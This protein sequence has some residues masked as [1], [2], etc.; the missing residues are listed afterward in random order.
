MFSF[1]HLVELKEQPKAVF[2]LFSDHQ[3]EQFTCK[4]IRSSNSSLLQ[5]HSFFLS[6]SLPTKSD[7]PFLPSLYQSC[8]HLL[9]AL[10]LL[11]PFFFFST[12]NLKPLLQEGLGWFCEET[13]KASYC[14]I[15]DCLSV[16]E[17]VNLLVSVYVTECSKREKIGSRSWI[18]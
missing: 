12:I 9:L 17:Y 13:E 8:P 2:C 14:D 3:S 1:H 7:P 6:P 5:N 18:S 4:M 11:F 16:V 15:T 10:K